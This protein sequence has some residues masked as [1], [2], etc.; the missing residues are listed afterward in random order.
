MTP[1]RH[2]RSLTP[3]TLLGRTLLALAL[4]LPGLGA[5]ALLAPTPRT[6]WTTASP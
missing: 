2:L 3:R 1:H 4:A 6:R 5:G